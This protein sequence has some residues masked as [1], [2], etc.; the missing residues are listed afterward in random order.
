MITREEVLAQIR[1]VIEENVQDMFG[2]DLQEDT[3][4]NAEGNVDSMG[5]ILVVTKLEGIYNV[6]IPDEEWYEIRTLGDL[7][8]VI[9]KY[10]PEQ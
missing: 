2:T 9:L 4:L 8:D 1:T 7:A 3:V 6:K 5:F 10:M